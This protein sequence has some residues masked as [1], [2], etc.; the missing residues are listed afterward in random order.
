LPNPEVDSSMSVTPLPNPK[1][2]I[3]DKERESLFP[4]LIRLLKQEY[5]K[6]LD[7]QYYSHFSF[8]ETQTII[9][10]LSVFSAEVIREASIIEG[11]PTTSKARLR[12]LSEAVAK[13]IRNTCNNYANDMI[14]NED[15]K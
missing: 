14:N 11:N 9:D 8:L 2:N 6:L 10:I 5:D 13:Q 4:N 12:L 15:M 1:D 7:E 3:S